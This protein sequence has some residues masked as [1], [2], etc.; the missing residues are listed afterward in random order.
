MITRTCQI[1]QHIQMDIWYM[2]QAADCLSQLAEVPDTP[3]VASILINMVVASI[4]D[5]PAIH[6]QN[7][8]KTSMHTTLPA[9]ILLPSQQDTLK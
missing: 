6:T 4:P 7:K 3:A 5:R 9:D 8:I 1:Q 2:R